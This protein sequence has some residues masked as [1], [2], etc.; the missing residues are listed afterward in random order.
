MGSY[1]VSQLAAAAGISPD[2]VRYY[3]REGLLPPPQRTASGYRRFEA[4]MLDRLA[5][6]SGCRNLGL[7][8]ADIKDLLAVRDTGV[9]PCEPAERHLTR[10]L[11]EVDRRIA[12]L[13]ALR[14]QMAHMLAAIPT[15][16]CPPPEPGTWCV[17][18]D[19]ADGAQPCDHE[20]GGACRC[21]DAIV[22]A[23]AAD[24]ERIAGD[25]AGNADG[26]VSSDEHRS[27]RVYPTTART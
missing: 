1:T 22:T 26:S 23:V 18:A 20:E 24:A 11:A 10:R 15:G 5:F 9:C 3:E 27:V 17:R 6:I 8:L 21:T 25:I 12:E 14:A 19:G 4:S 2:T 7:T 13:T 16:D